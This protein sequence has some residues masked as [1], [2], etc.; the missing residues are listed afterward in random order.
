MKT[1]GDHVALYYN[2]IR[3]LNSAVVVMWGTVDTFGIHDRS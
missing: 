3:I 1:L 2:C